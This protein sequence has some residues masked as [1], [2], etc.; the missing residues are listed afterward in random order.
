M[1]NYFL[2]LF[3]AWSIKEKDLKK[4]TECYQNLICILLNV[5]ELLTAEQRNH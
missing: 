4:N 3:F 5:I 2:F 1:A